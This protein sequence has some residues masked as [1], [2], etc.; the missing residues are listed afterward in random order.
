MK[1]SLLTILLI[2]FLVSGIV[3]Q[4]LPTHSLTLRAA[5]INYQAPNRDNKKLFTDLNNAVEIGYTRQL[6]NWFSVNLPVRIGAANFPRLDTSDN[7]TGYSKKLNYSGIDL[8]AKANLLASKRIS[9][10]VYLGIGGALEDWDKFYAQAPVGLGLDFKLNEYISLNAQTDYR[11]AFKEGYDNWQHAAGIRACLCGL[12]KDMDKDGI[13]DK[14]DLC[15]D[16]FGLKQFEGCPDTDNDG[17]SDNNDKCPTLAGVAENMGC[18]ADSDKD[19]VYDVDDMCPTV[20]GTVKGCPDRDRDGVADADD[21][22][23]DVAG[24]ATL[25]GCPDRDRDGLADASDKCPDQAGPANTG[26]CPDKDKDGV[27]DSD[28]KCPDVAGPASNNGCPLA[29]DTDKDGITDDKDKCPN[30]PG[31]A[32]NGG[33]PEIKVED[34][35]ILDVAMRAVQFDPGTAT[36]TKSSY[37]NLDEVVSVLGRYPEMNLAVEGHTDNQGD[38]KMNQSLSDKRA[39]ACVD[40]LV[41][42]GIASSRLT[43]TGYGETRPIGDNAN[44][45]GRKLNRRT[46]FVPIWR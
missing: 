19:G 6:N 26:G 29:V 3:A 44:A 2:T 24:L 45:A 31:V 8:L 9:P 17:I 38:V 42:K 23:P 32:S 20:A 10:Y 34:K 39:K 27:S 13:S 35:K 5:W 28:D 40:Y 33:C 22:C 12:E 36:I 1:N 43:G 25:G 41:K 46:E 18:P 11:L 16:V 4:D 14:K 30:T 15:P 37:G 7:V 21:K